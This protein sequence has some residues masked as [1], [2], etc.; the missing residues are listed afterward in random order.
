MKRVYLWLTYCL[1]INCINKSVVYLV[2]FFLNI[3]AT[4]SLQAQFFSLGTDPSRVS[5]RSVES[6][7]F[8]FIFPKGYDS[9][10]SRYLY[11]FDNLKPEV[12]SPLGVKCSPI[13]VILHPY[14]V[15]GNGLVAWA[16]KRIDLITTPLAGRG[17]MQSWDRQLA[18]HELR[19]VAQM[20]ALNRGVFKVLYYLGGEQVIGAAAGLYSSKWEMEG[21]AVVSETELS[22][23]GRGRDPRFLAY[24]RA[25]F[26]NGD[27]RDY[28]RWSIGS[29]KDYEPDVYS[30]GYMIS[31]SIRFMSA[32]PSYIGKVYD[33]RVKH[34]YNPFVIGDSYKR[35]TGLG[36]RSEIYEEVIG[37]MYSRW[38]RED[39]LGAPYSNGS[40]IFAPNGGY[41]NYSSLGY[42]G[43][44]SLVVIKSDLDRANELWLCKGGVEERLCGVASQFSGMDVLDNHKILWCENTPSVRW[45]LEN[46]SNLVEYNLKTKKRRFITKRGRLFNP[47]VDPTGRFIS[48]TNYPVNGGSELIVLSSKD[49]SQLYTIVAP[50]SLQI[51]E[52]AWI[53]DTIYVSVA[54][55]NR[56]GIYRAAVLRDSKWEE[57]MSKRGEIVWSLKSRGE[58]LLYESSSGGRGDIFSLNPSLGLIRKLS[59]SRFGAREPEPSPDGV[60]FIDYNVHGGDIVLLPERDFVNKIWSRGP[61]GDSEIANVI[62]LQRGFVDTISVPQN[63][64]YKTKRYNKL[65]GLLNIHSWSP[66]FYD[67]D[68][69][70][71]GSFQ[72]IN[73]VVSPGFILQSQS[74]L[75]DASGSL[76]Y[77]W[78]NG[79]NSAHLGFTYRGLYPVFNI[80][81]DFNERKRIKIYTVDLPGGV[82]QLD[83]NESKA[84][85]F[86]ARIRTYIPF[87]YSR[88]G[89]T[90]FVIPRLEFRFTNDQFFSNEKERYV[91]Y[92]QLKVGMQAYALKSMAKRNIFP[93]YGVGMNVQFSSVPFAGENFGTMFYSHLYGYLP[94]VLPNHGLKLSYSYQKQFD[95]GKRYLQNSAS[96]F[97]RGYVEYPVPILHM[98]TLDYT[99]PIYFSSFKIPFFL[100]VKRLQINP[101][102]DYAYTNRRGL[103]KN[104]SSVGGDFIADMHIFEIS[105]PIS[106]G[107]R[108]AVRDDGKFIS[109][110]I[111]K[112]PL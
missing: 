8:R 91:N 1:T 12:T 39:S 111:F 53:G 16:P 19:H 75:G 100:Y 105:L 41:T 56:G 34:F 21:D 42:I 11:L 18:L 82:L 90:R 79:R 6:P 52:S 89:F 64:R 69:L 85:Y 58:E 108:L 84:P 67:I 92:S 25:A 3:F 29:L 44:D 59:N 40:R 109:N 50:D 20:E 87:N 68:E 15:S 24:Y 45:E 10:A 71:S 99:L 22:E 93:K 63:I 107:V 30:F 83:E 5:W 28:E 102:C 55:V 26:L 66:F 37:M 94:G 38:S 17:Y 46:F 98:F 49:Y 80:Q 13:D 72:K 78:N 81:A 27:F 86:T 60:Y 70:M 76:G 65:G 61:E 48:L 23:V 110:I 14:S 7:S 51:K 95:S 112:V 97:P 43:I 104:L 9:I 103:I 54:G 32:A 35:A 57:V 77:R 62:S 96:D 33:Y 2:L 73:E 31:S 4:I 101:F 106:F 88:G 47:S 74:L 36:S